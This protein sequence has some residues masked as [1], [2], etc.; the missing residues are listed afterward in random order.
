MIW[1][2]VQ[3]SFPHQ[4]LLIEA[5]QAR[6]EN[7][8]RILDQIAVVDT[9]PVG[10]TAMMGYVRLHKEEPQREMF[11][12]HTDRQ[13]PDIHVRKWMGMRGAR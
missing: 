5:I 2:E 1:T 10:E 4:W 9:F 8:M 7:D 6:T 12:L 3:K 11:V 13:Q